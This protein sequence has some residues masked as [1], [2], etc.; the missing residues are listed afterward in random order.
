MFP[1]YYLVDTLNRA[2]NYNAGLGD[3]WY[4]LLVLLAFDGLFILLGAKAIRRRIK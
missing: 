3:N 4:N 1:S 2:V